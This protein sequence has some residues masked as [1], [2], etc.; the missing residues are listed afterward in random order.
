M[1]LVFLTLAPLSSNAGHLARLSFELR[2]LSKINEVSI[3]CLGKDP[4]NEETKNIYRNVSFIHLPVKFNGWEV[5]NLLETA[6]TIKNVI[7]EIH[8]NVVILMMEV[9]DLM[10]ELNKNLKDGIKF[11]TV[12]HAMPFLAAPLEPSGDFESDILE[13]CQSDIE[14]YKKDYILKHYKEACAVFDDALIIANN[15]TVEFY[16]KTYFPNLKISVLLPTLIVQAHP[17]IIIQEPFT[18]DFIYMARMESG[19]GIEYLLDILNRISLILQRKIKVAILGKTDDLLTKKALEKLLEEASAKTS[20]VEVAYFGWADKNM[21]KDILTKSSVFLYPSH[22]DNF[23]TVLNEALSFGLPVVT[24]DVLFY[25]L[26]YKTAL[27]VKSVPLFD[28]QAFAEKAVE[29][30]LDRKQLSKEAIDFVNSFKS[31]EETA[32]LDTDVFEEIIDKE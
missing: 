28:F 4:D 31:P 14:G 16:L 10:R 5:V 12:V 9:W 29:A 11:V 26:N 7:E 17:D 13:Y 25:R 22:Y 3:I 8:P 6:N 24:W 27:A 21:K 23:P 19:K 30:T 2:D 15:K 1:K 32:Q 18:Y 20:F